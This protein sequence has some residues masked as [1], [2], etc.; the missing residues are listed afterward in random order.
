M[1][2]KLFSMITFCSLLLVCK[3]VNNVEHFLTVNHAVLTLSLKFIVMNPLAALSHHQHVMKVYFSFPIIM[4][5]NFSCIGLIN[6]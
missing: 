2:V 6:I 1:A 5:F 3:K 4:L